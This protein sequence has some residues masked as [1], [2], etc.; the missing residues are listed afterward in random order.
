[1][2]AEDEMRAQKI[3]FIPRIK[4]SLKT[5][6]NSMLTGEQRVARL[7]TR[8]EIPPS[9]ISLSLLPHA[10]VCFRK[11]VGEVKLPSPRLAWVTRFTRRA[12]GRHLQAADTCVALLFKGAET[13]QQ[14]GKKKKKDRRGF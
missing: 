4:L 7:G 11:H 3:T 1:M 2:S 14:A 9:A 12:P 10:F 6:L 5:S 8:V 13:Q